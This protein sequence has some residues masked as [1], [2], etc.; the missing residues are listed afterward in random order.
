MARKSL[1]DLERSPKGVRVEDLLAVLRDHGFVIR[2]GTRHGYIAVRGK[3]T[4][5]IPRHRKVLL[6]VYVRLAVKFIRGEQQ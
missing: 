3:Q 5:T 2:A 1:A 6:P 4:L